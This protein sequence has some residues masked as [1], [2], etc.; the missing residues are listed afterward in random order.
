L[1][2]NA[3][4]GVTIGGVVTTGVLAGIARLAL[5]LDRRPERRLAGIG[6]AGFAGGGADP[7]K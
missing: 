7:A 4:V 1:Q 3:A 2:R 6:G 5:G